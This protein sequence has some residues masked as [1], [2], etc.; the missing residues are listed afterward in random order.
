MSRFHKYFRKTIKP[1][2]I[3]LIKKFSIKRNKKNKAKYI[4]NWI[5]VVFKDFSS[6]IKLDRN[7]KVKARLIKIKTTNLF[8]LTPVIAKN[9]KLNNIK[10]D[11][12]FRN[13][14]ICFLLI[15]YPF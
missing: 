3:K 11:D 2:G 7:K 9:N 4:D 12:I 13:L 1:K 15:N 6:I 8:K 10:Y 14:D 5:K